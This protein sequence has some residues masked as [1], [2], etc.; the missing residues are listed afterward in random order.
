[1][2]SRFTPPL[3][4][5]IDI[6]S[7]AIHQSDTSAVPRFRYSRQYFVI[8]Q[9]CLCQCL[10]YVVIHISVSRLIVI[11]LFSF[12][13]PTSN[14]FT[15]L[16]LPLLLPLIYLL[17]LLTTWTFPFLTM[18]SMCFVIKVLSLSLSSPIVITFIQN[19]VPVLFHL[20]HCS[21]FFLLNHADFWIIPSRELSLS[22]RLL[23]LFFFFCVRGR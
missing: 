18:F 16:F 21:L 17:V 20:H 2:F 14:V 10:T 8:R 5:F 6:S 13:F 4:I 3:H 12:A 9:K 11:A 22:L 15:T 19:Y 7:V 23:R 1:M